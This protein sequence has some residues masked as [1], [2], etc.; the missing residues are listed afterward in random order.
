MREQ[1]SDR[2]G[3]LLITA[4]IILIFAAVPIGIFLVTFIHQS[5]YLKKTHWFFDSPVSSYI[6]MVAMLL[7]IPV[8]LIFV[9]IYL[10]KSYASKKRAL[11]T[12]VLSLFIVAVTAA[13][14]F[15]SLDNYYY[16]DRSGLYYDELWKIN[17]T[18]YLWD[19]ITE[20]KQINKKDGGTLVPEK[21]IFTYGSNVIEL[22]LT[23][24]LRN[25]IEPVIGYIENTKGLKLIY[26]E[27][28]VE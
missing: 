18:A 24:K 15:L 25:E 6:T 8:L 16:M 28:T 10:F 5:F 19:N 21:M 7:T 26:E 13:G 2:A 20:M 27:R 3:S 17:K 14:G 4:A 11:I 1:N 9:A 23:P 12:G 22:P